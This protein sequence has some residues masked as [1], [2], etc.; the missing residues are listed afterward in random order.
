MELSTL[1]RNWL[2]A[3]YERDEMRLKMAAANADP[4]PVIQIRGGLPALPG[5][6]IT[7]PQINNGQKV[8]DPAL[9]WGPP[10]NGPCDAS[11][12]EAVLQ[13]QKGEPATT[14]DSPSQPN[15]S[16]PP[17]PNQRWF[18]GRPISDDNPDP[19]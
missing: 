4:N 10:D 13:I 19:T 14:I 3:K 1:T 9:P 8:T 5:T 18:R 12:G 16:A 2:S 15:G 11:P 17:D 7:M 6:N